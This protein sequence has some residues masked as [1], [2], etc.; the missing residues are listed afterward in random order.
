MCNLMHA[1]VTYYSIMPTLCDIPLSMHATVT[2]G[3]GRREEVLQRLHALY[4]PGCSS[5]W[6]H[7]A[8][9]REGHIILE[10]CLILPMRSFIHSAASVN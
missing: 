8:D 9:S 3:R 5:K 1:T 6:G 2:M 10:L 7:A 4:H